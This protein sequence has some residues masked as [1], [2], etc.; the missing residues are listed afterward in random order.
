MKQIQV[1]ILVLCCLV[2]G[3]QSAWADD[4]PNNIVFRETFDG[5]KGSGGR[6]GVYSGNIANSGIQYDN[7]GWTATKCG[8]ASQCVSF[9]TGSNNGVLTRPDISFFGARYALLTFSAAGWGDNS[10]NNLKVETNDGFTIESD[11]N[12]LE[13][14]NAVWNN[15]TVLIKVT[16]ISATLQLTFTGKR[17]FLDDV[18]VRAL[19]KAPDPTL[20][21]EFTFFPLTTEEKAGNR[22]TLTPFSYTETYYTTDGST[23]SITNGTKTLQSTGITIHGTTTVNAIS[24]V[25]DMASEVVT[26]TYTQGNTVNGI[27]EFC[28]LADDTEVRLFL[29]DDENHETRVLYYDESSHQLFVRDKSKALCVDFDETTTFS[30]MPKYNQH[31]A[32]WIVGK[33]TTDN[34]MPKLVATAYTNAHFLAIAD[35]VTESQTEPN[36]ITA[37]EMDSHVAD[38]VT[39][40]EQRVGT[41]LTVID[42]FGTS[43]Y[44]GALADLSG[45]VIPNG[46]TQQI[47]PF[48]QNDIS[49]VVYVIN[50]DKDFTSPAT[51]ID[52]ATVRLKLTL[53]KDGWNTFAAPFSITSFDGE[54]REFSGK[55]GN[56]MNFTTATAIEAGVPYLLKPTQDITDK[57]YSGVTL[58]SQTAKSVTF[59]DFSFV[60]TYSPRQLTT[61]MTELFLT[62]DGILVYPSNDSEA[63]LKGLSAYVQVPAN[64]HV[65]I[66]IEGYEAITGISLSEKGESRMENVYDLPGRKIING[67]LQKGVYIVN[68]KKLIIK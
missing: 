67:P 2:L 12:I 37:T 60:A 28:D 52:N 33:K 38:W 66:S 4:D 44:D 34:G 21:D 5:T 58:K 46:S 10:K 57:T 27:S 55:D 24:Y 6:D 8:V 9:G 62:T 53:S 54:I 22:V 49:G 45:I 15:Y 43:V 18:V 19:R 17:G 23:P 51:D 64:S 1:F 7:E 56:T 40:N 36:T 31:I 11:N 3:H 35:P 68:G 65:I 32:G 61:D 13:L 29:A 48:T 26:R 47:A 59:D 30:P 41:D 14:E 63:L 20:Q 25:G 42:R 39:I 16:D 50:E